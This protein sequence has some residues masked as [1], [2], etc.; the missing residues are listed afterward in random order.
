MSVRGVRDRDNGARR[1]GTS[2]C[3]SGGSRGRLGRWQG[4]SLGVQALHAID[5]TGGPVT[6]IC[7]RSQL[8]SPIDD[9]YIFHRPLFAEAVVDLPEVRGGALTGWMG[10][11]WFGVNVTAAVEDC[12]G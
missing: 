6:V 1:R 9:I 10:V 11:H 5:S 8:E 7:G 2:D 12:R 3:R 4:L